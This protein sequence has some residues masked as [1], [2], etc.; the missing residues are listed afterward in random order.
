MDNNLDKIAACAVPEELIPQMTTDALLETYLTH[1]MAV[2]LFAFDRTNDGFAILKDYYEFGLNEL[3]KREDLAESMLKRYNQIE[4]YT[5]E[6][7]SMLRADEQELAEDK[8]FDDSLE[9][10]LIEVAAAQLNLNTRSA[11]NDALENALYEKYLA[12]SENQDF[13]GPA[14]ACYY[15]ALAEKNGVETYNYDFYIQTPNGSPVLMTYVEQDYSESAKRALEEKYVKLYEN[16]ELIGAASPFYNCHSYAW[17]STLYWMQDPIP[18][19]DDGSYRGSPKAVVGANVYYDFP[20]DKET[21]K[22]GIYSAV[23]SNVSSSGATVTVQSKWGDGGLFR[24]SYSDCPYFYG[25][26]FISYWVR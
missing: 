21:G 20:I 25:Y 5:A 6:K 12:K 7:A 11:A 13:Y 1:P 16:A 22:G 19:M 15:T 3:M 9:M 17:H 23:V 4:V 24:H 8:A 14:A 26:G 2:N 10:Q 18:Y